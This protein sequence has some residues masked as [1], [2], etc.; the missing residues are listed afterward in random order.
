[1]RTW[2][3]LA[4]KV[5]R[6]PTS[7]RVFV[8]RRLK[9]FGAIALQDAVW[10]LPATQQSKEQYQWLAAE[11]IELKGDASVWEGRLTLSG[12]DEEMVCRF[13]DEVDDNYRQILTKLKR[14][15]PDLAA[16]SREY[17]QV[18]ARD[19]FRSAL[20][21]KTREALIAARGDVQP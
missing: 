12:Q 16:L 7:A 5:P 9:R 2:L 11:I 10:V 8:W 1:V 18:Q 20:G 4:Y 17:Q 21:R 6:D 3:L 15:R 19:Y 13:K 14:K